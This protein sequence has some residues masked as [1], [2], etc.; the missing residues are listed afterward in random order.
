LTRVAGL[1]ED[2]NGFAVHV[3]DERDNESIGVSVQCL[4]SELPWEAFLIN[5]SQLTSLSVI[6]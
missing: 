2:L 4:V 3:F 5:F 6:L 1:S